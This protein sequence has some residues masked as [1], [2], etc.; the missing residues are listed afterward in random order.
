MET[1]PLL[2]LES[3]CEYLT[4]GEPHRA[5]L[6]AFASVSRTCRAVAQRERFYQISIDVDDEQKF[7]ERVRRLERMLD[8]TRSRTAVRVLKIGRCIDGSGE[9]YSTSITPVSDGIRPLRKWQPRKA[10]RPDEW[11][12]PL[13]QF[14]SSLPLKDLVWASKEQ[15][16]RCVLSAL[17]T[18]IPR[19][20][21]HA[22][23][24]EL[25]S[26]YQRGDLQDIE[27]DDYML[28]TSP[29]LH[30]II[31]PCSS[32]DATGC[33]NY[34][35]EAILWLAAGLAPNL[36]HVH[37]WDNTL[38]ASGEI[39]SRREDVRL[40]WRGFH[41]RSDYKWS[42]MPDTN[43]QLQSLIFDPY[44]LIPG[45]QL[46][47]WENHT[48]FSVL[49][50]LSILRQTE[51]DALKLLVGVAERDGLRHLKALDL[52]VVSC[53]YEDR[54]EAE[55]AMTRLL[56]LLNPLVELAIVGVRDFAFDA[57]LEKHGSSLQ[58]LRVRNL[59]L[60]PRQVTQ[61]R[62]SCPGI[63]ELCIEILR[64]SGD[65]DEIKTYQ[66]L[67]SMRCL[68]SLSLILQC[69]EYHPDGGPDDP[70]PHM[71]W[72]SYD[73][74]DQEAMAVAI[75]QVF[76]NAAVDES[77]ARSI[78]QELL[79]AH[80]S[81]KAGLPP[82]ITSI[83]LKVGGTPVL[84]GQTTD[85]EFQGILAWIGRSWACRRDPRD[86]HQNVITVEEVD[87]NARLRSVEMLETDMDGFYG[88]EQYRGIWESLWPK[89]GAGWREDWRSFP[90]AAN[91][92]KFTA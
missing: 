80:T 18:H 88:S 26:L 5:S 59:I 45:S 90:F 47:C 14:I 70:A 51:L 28:A 54:E 24:F 73:E 41:P 36:K 52:A 68:E 86:T 85:S 32:Y 81:V 48:D 35:E 38:R 15:I 91:A 72:S 20:R 84:N 7:P 58:V 33:A 49:R 57:A 4:Y 79:A 23:E 30:S 37:M 69:S 11:W 42:Q 64:S 78:F 74:E 83:H 25:W 89:T 76:V 21:L 82:R 50:S 27:D 65:E 71:G 44:Q 34:H 1:L 16:P 8:E 66:T 40:E 63:R 60:S 53:E 10:P 92:R 43:G 3:V 46:T 9:G 67:G 6:L 77:L 19:C 13:V 12:R 17:E 75:R 62:D 55:S 22:H 29:C 61:L 56:L 87:S 31:A 39:R 2:V